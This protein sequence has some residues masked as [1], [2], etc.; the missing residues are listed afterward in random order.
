MTPTAARHVCVTGATRGIGRAIA[1]AF[2]AAGARVTVH[3]RTPASAAQA[4]ADLGAAA[5]IAADVTDAA[6]LDAALAEAARQSGPIEVLVNNAGGADTAPLARLSVDGLRAMMA[7]NVEP[8]LVA[9]KAVVPAMKAAGSGRIVT[10]ASTAALKAYPYVGAYCAAK[11]AA[12]GLTRT[13]AL[14]LA[15]AGITVNAVCPGFTD[16][17]LVGGA[18]DNLQAK[19]GRTRDDL[20]AEFTKTNPMGRLIRP[21]EVADAVLWLASP[22]AGSVTGQAIVVAGG[23]L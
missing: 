17:D 7:L 23:E 5:H 2:V 16:T 21:D 3:G 11:H 8:L 12:L 9:A 22:T 4:A 14:E 19:T 10:V 20:L 15:G 13:L 18:L 1:A 6:A